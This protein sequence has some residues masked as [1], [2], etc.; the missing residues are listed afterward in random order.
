MTKEK[1][2]SAI[3]AGSTT[4]GIEL[5]S[6]RIK[7]VLIDENHEV[8]AN[9][10][11]CWENSLV[12]GLWTYALEDAV[13]GL[14]E[15][16]A[17][18]KDDVLVRYGITL[19]RVGAIGIS[20]MMHGYIPL[21][22]AGKQLE[23]FL[24][25]RNTNT[26]EAA[27]Q[28]TELFRFNIP[29]RW[30][31]AQLY[32]AVLEDRPHVKDLDYMTTLAG[33]VH[34]LL[35]GERVLGVGDA[36]GMFPIDPDQQTYDQTML[37]RFDAHIANRS[38]PW[39]IRD[40]L[41]K[42]LPAG[43]CAGKLTESGAKLLDRDGDLAS[44]IPM[45]PPE[46]D[47]GTGM[48]AT[49]SVDAATGNISAGTSVFA[50]VV[51]ERQLSRIYQDIDI[52]ATP[53]GRPVAMVHCNN[54]TS[55]IDAWAHIFQEFADAAGM[56]VPNDQVYQILYKQ[57]LQGAL[58]CDGVMA[59]NYL[60]GEPVTGT[61]NGVPM[62]FRT[63]DSRFTLANFMR[64]QIYSVL[65]S[66]ALGMRILFGENVRI[67]RLT[68]HGGLFKTAGVA[69]KY[70]SAALHAPIIVMNNAGEGGPY[71]MAVLA[72]YMLRR[73]KCETLEAYLRDRVFDDAEGAV[74]TANM[75]EC[76]GYERYLSNYDQALGAEQMAAEALR[77]ENVN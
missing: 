4:L 44:G 26:A 47:A 67:A 41:P 76:Q 29:L 52:V 50:M 10:S 37:D 15:S 62:L 68:A 57:S 46:G 72:A 21:D 7:A 18:L 1:N 64:S 32:Q 70:L 6:T 31:V 16:Y 8:L 12:R 33:Y 75:A 43:T 23:P 56:T 38:Y 3:Q 74:Y 27:S 24:T 60:A 36:S 11:F 25:W 35:S 55:E 63:A 65:A 39:K 34:L 71:G 13:S 61:S 69:Q 2:I 22:H 48:V 42:V 40:I 59:Y 54:G 49:N 5:G 20:G 66:L 53:S 28:L 45:A 77:K 14:Q 19:H 58:D 30:S 9:G 73:E 51:L 17:R